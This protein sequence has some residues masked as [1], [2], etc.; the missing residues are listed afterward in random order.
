[1]SSMKRKRVT[2]LLRKYYPAPFMS[3]K[4]WCQHHNACPFTYT[5]GMVRVSK[6][7]SNHDVWLAYR[8]ARSPLHT[9]V[10]G[11][12]DCL[13]GIPYTENASSD[14]QRGWNGCKSATPEQRSEHLAF[15]KSF[16]GRPKKKATGTPSDLLEARKAVK[17]NRKDT[18]P[19]PAQKTNLE[20]YRESS[21]MGH[22]T[23]L[24]MKKNMGHLYS[25][26][27]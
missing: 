12:S 6:H 23:S 10:Q 14:W 21:S 13:I 27:R 19:I 26:C 15:T 4:E 20:I 5:P 7:M 24:P 18:D 22:K 3:F 17:A 8:A 25:T 11:Y 9:Y 1:M 2:K 16:K